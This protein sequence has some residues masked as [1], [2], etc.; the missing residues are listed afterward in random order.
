MLKGTLKGLGRE[1]DVQMQVLKSHYD[2]GLLNLK[3]L[4]RI[5]EL[6]PKSEHVKD[7]IKN[8]HLLWKFEEIGY[9]VPPQYLGDE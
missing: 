8:E 5:D 4:T 6:I 2:S 1:H 9:G 3:E 7:P